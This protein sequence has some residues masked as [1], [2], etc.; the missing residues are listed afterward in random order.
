MRWH[1]WLLPVLVLPSATLAQAPREFVTPG[2]N[3]VLEGIP[4]I[5]TRLADEINRYTETRGA[6]L[7]GWHP[8]RR[9]MLIFTRFADAVQVHRVK[10]PG[11]A[12]TQ[13][14]FVKDGVEDATYE[15]TRGD[16]FSKASGGDENYQKNRYDVATGL[17]TL[18]TDG[19]SR[20]TGGVW[21]VAGDQYAYGSTRRNGR[22]VDLWV[23]DPADP[24]SDRLVA[25][26]QGGGW[27]A[28]DFSPDG[29]QLLAGEYVSA[30]ESYLWLIDL[31]T[32]ARTP[33]TPRGG[34]QPVAYPRAEF[35]KDGKGIYVT[36]DRDS[37][38]QRL[39]YV[40][41][42]TKNH[43]DL[44]GHIPW[45]VQ[46]FQLSWDG[47]TIAFVTNE[48]RL[49]VLHL[50][51]TASGR[52]RRA[53]KLP[54]GVAG[55]IQWRKN[56]RELGLTL[57]SARNPAEA[58][59]LNVP[60]G[61]LERWTESE[62]GSI[63]TRAFAEPGVVRWKSFDGRLIS[64]W[65][66]TPPGKF[67]GRRPVVVEI[68]GGPESQARPLFRPDLNYF[69]NELGVAV[70]RP[71]VRGSSGY[72][73]TFL[74]LDNAYLR[75]DSYKDIGALL[76]WVKTRPDL[77]AD[78]VMVTGG[79]YG[80]H[81]TLAVA[82]YYPERIRC[83]LDLVGQANLVTFLENTS[84]YR[85]DLRRA[86]Y[87]DERDPAMRAFLNRIAPVNN[88]AKITKPLFA[89]QG[90]NDPRVPRSESEQMVRTVR[91]NGV[92][93]WYLLARDEGHNFAKKQNED[94]LLTCTVL[95]MKEYLLK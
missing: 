65:L 36:T 60:T 64:G 50:L 22:D 86:E 26:L 5:P 67:T 75:E 94:F 76:D 63:N 29:R 37:E 34:G 48:D 35:S 55:G 33:I 58:Y 38:F 61:H 69:V 25:Q 90:A 46:G 7:A 84:P 81:M 51:D 21:S 39:A 8:T 2:E 68:H 42:A 17:V 62:T 44:T 74:K 49:S 66:Y 87:G 57:T 85:K 54:V 15:P 23:M 91:K 73:K 80:G 88:A 40:E 28:L 47:K 77:D 4:K 16:Y 20:N 6:S 78:R 56:N 72:G 59:S 9:E 79:S 92:P 83:A 52:E 11:G 53:P 41:L 1:V 70:I 12:R 13:L 18:L 45:D 32:G 93:V 71:N 19:K 3:L 24:K 95:F 89:V 10:F 30:T 43:T 14:T 82:T 27:G 31:A